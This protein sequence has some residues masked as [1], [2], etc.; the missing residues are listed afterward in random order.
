L[1]IE[2]FQDSCLFV[3]L[4]KQTAFMHTCGVGLAD[5][6]EVENISGQ[7]WATPVFA[8]ALTG[9]VY[10]STRGPRAATLAAVVGAVASTVYWYGGTYFN[11]VLLGKSGRF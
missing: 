9:G 4:H 11:D 2:Y 5:Y 7:S 8:G 6:L 10:K 3:L 1:I